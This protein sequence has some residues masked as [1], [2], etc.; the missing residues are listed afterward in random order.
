MF[1]VFMGALYKPNLLDI[2]IKSQILVLG[3]FGHN[4]LAMV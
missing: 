1:C 4:N 2:G 3:D